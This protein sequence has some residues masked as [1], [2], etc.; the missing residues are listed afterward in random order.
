MEAGDTSSDDE[1]V[2]VQRQQWSTVNPN[3][4]GTKI[5]AFEN[6]DLSEDDKMKLQGLHGR[7]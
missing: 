4:V 1:D 2:P 7:I 6:P 3:Q 5:P